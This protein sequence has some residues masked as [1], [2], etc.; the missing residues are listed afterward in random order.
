MFE[1]LESFEVSDTNVALQVLHSGAFSNARKLK[2]ADFGKVNKI[3]YIDEPGNAS[4]FQVEDYKNDQTSTVPK[5]IV[6]D[7]PT[8]SPGDYSDDIGIFE[9]DYK[10]TSLDLYQYYYGI[11][12]TSDYEDFFNE[13]GTKRTYLKSIPSKMF[14][15]CTNLNRFN[16]L[17][18]NTYAIPAS[19]R[20]IGENAFE[21]TGTNNQQ[22]LSLIFPE[23]LDET[24]YGVTSMGSHIFGA[25]ASNFPFNNIVLPDP[26][27]TAEFLQGLSTSL[28][29]L[30]SAKKSNLTIQVPFS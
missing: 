21:E 24:Q 10:L 15:N 1:N 26:N 7:D 22:T 8:N 28:G 2:T 4:P 23:N 25:T 30:S 20:S 5:P 16:S 19:V 29:V 11:K 14:K 18:P 12:N 27:P 9:N 6:N 17:K 13:D 3:A